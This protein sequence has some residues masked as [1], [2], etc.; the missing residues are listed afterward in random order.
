M[1]FSNLLLGLIHKSRP[2]FS[3]QFHP[4]AKGGPLDSAYLF[5]IYLENVQKY[6]QSQ[7]HSQPTRDSIPSPLL[8]DLLSK[9][10]VGVDLTQGIRNMMALNATQSQE[11][12]IY[13]AGTV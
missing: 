3:T 5:D 6:K 11:Q 13:A 4:E 10:R 12:P 7:S 9:E 8:V 1:N 2:I